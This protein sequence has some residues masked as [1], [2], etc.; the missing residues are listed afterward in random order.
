M[1]GGK[2][3]ESGEKEGKDTAGETN[4][5]MTRLFKSPT[6]PYGG[7]MEKQ[8]E[9]VEPYRARKGQAFMTGNLP[10][11]C[12]SI[13]ASFDF[14]AMPFFRTLTRLGCEADKLKEFL[15]LKSRIVF[16]KEGDYIV[17]ENGAIKSIHIIMSGEFLR[18]KNIHGDQYGISVLE[19]GAFSSIEEFFTLSLG[20]YI[21]S[22]VAGCHGVVL[23]LDAPGFGT[24]L[25]SQGVNTSFPDFFIPFISDLLSCVPLLLDLLPTTLK[26]IAAEFK[27]K[28]FL[29]KDRIFSVHAK[30]AEVRGRARSEATS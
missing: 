24:F 2:S 11:D 15:D 4:R 16:V 3:Q 21:T 23:E 9:I 6:S 22:V 18:Q 13:C 8:E 10:L 1:F 30:A 12:P 28:K 5:R 29:K 14:P 20:S 7:D 25:T 26:L 17:E 27:V 19:S